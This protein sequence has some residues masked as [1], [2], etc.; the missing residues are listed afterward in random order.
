MVL[1]RSA[2]VTLSLICAAWS[3]AAVTRCDEP[4]SL[5]KTD[6]HRGRDLFERVWEPDKTGDG[7][8]LG[9]LFNERSCVACHLLGGV[10]VRTRKTSIF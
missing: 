7:D 8:G 1:A 5:P 4:S 2:A 6:V 9:P 10:G 3:S